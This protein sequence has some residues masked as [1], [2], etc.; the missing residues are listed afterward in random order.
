VPAALRDTRRRPL[1]RGRR[2]GAPRPA[3]RPARQAKCPGAPSTGPRT[4]SKARA[5]RRLHRATSRKRRRCSRRP[6]AGA[7][8]A[9]AQGRRCW[10]CSYCSGSAPWPCSSTARDRPSSARPSRGSAGTRLATPTASRARLTGTRPR[11][12]ASS[13][14][15]TPSRPRPPGRLQSSFSPGNCPLPSSPRPSRRRRPPWRTP[16]RPGRP[17]GPSRLGTAVARTTHPREPEQPTRAPPASRGID[18]STEQRPPSP[19][20]AWP[21]RRQRQPSPKLPGKFRSVR[22][23]GRRLSRRD[24]RPS[25]GPANPPRRSS[26]RT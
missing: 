17:P 15:Q 19:P 7:T 25:R 12:T 2:P 18:G 10:C 22:P 26:R 16:S 8:R 3:P 11:R 6:A 14:R 23:T 20:S 9:T 21:V 1:P 24:R 13:L 5:P 4:G